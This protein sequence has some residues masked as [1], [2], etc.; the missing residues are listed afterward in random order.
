MVK[1]KVKVRKQFLEKDHAIELAMSIAAAQEEKSKEKLEKQLIQVEK[2]HS[3]HLSRTS[4]SSKAKLK[5]TMAMLS[6]Q[7]AKLQKDKVKKRRNRTKGGDGS[8]VG[9]TAKAAKRPGK[10]VAFALG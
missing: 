5:E 10:R 7:K 2:T 4:E 1:A 9:D 6:A 3:K 8:E